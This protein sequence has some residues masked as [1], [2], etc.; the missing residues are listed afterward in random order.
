VF[1]LFCSFY[2]ATIYLQI[3]V[4]TS[5]EMNA[6]VKQALENNS[7]QYLEI[8]VEQEYWRWLT[9]FVNSTYREYYYEFEGNKFPIPDYRQHAFPNLNVLMSP[10][11]MT[12]RRM[13]MVPNEDEYTKA[14][15]QEGWAS[16]GF[17]IYDSFDGDVETA[18][19]YGPGEVFS[20]Q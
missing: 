7:V 14:Y 8:S 5:Y 19:S 18:D 6:A 11:R 13:R 10:V 1:L 15:I 12:Q 20:Y 16:L 9:D 3:N 4:E 17:G 2:T